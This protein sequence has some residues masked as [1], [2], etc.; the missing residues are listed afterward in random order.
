MKLAI[1]CHQHAEG[2]FK[3]D[4]HRHFTVKLESLP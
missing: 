3:M 2:K 1:V 4:P